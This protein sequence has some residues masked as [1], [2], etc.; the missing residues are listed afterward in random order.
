M[1]RRNW[2]TIN[3]E[4]YKSNR[5]IKPQEETDAIYLN[6]DQLETILQLDLSKSKSLENA[7]DLFLVGC[8]TGLRF[9]DFSELSNRDVIKGDFIHIKTQKTGASVAIPILPPLKEI[10]NRYKDQTE[11]GLP[12]SIS[13]QKLN[14]YI[15]EI[16]KIAGFDQIVEVTKPTAGSRKTIKVPFYQLITTHT[17]RRSFATN[18]YRIYKLPPA[19]IMKVTGHKSEAVFFK[20]IRITP[21]ENAQMILDAVMRKHNNPA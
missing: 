6:T 9:S 5:F 8:W 14:A 10:M 17:A 15:K 2:D 3:N 13:N 12:H 18:M 16:G 11:N 19:T 4:T 20:Y 7:R 1:R 21:E